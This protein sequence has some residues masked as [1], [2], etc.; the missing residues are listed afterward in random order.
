MSFAKNITFSFW[1]ESWKVYVIATIYVCA[2][3]RV[4]HER[5]VTDAIRTHFRIS[6]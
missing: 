6:K 5:T 1:L 4:M 3:R 2:A